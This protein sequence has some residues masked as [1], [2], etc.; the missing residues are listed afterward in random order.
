M[1]FDLFTVEGEEM[2]ELSGVEDTEYNFTFTDLCVFA[3]ISAPLVKKIQNKFSTGA[4]RMKGRRTYYSL[5]EAQL[6]RTVADM[7]RLGMEYFEIRHQLKVL[8]NTRQLYV[9]VRRMRAII[10]RLQKDFPEEK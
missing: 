10:E 3:D 7:R 6:I 1:L 4:K 9:E 2:N 8:P 5:R